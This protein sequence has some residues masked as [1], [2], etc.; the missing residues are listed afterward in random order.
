MSTVASKLDDIRTLKRRATGFRNLK[1]FKKALAIFEQAIAELKTLQASDQIT[2]TEASEV[3]VEL[4]DTYGMEGGTYSR[5]DELPNHLELALEQYRTGLEIERIDKKSTYNASNVIRL[6]ITLEK[7]P[8]D[9]AMMEDIDRVI[10]GLGTD[11][12]GER[13]DEFWAWA[14]LG[15][16]YLLRNDLNKARA[17]YR[18]AMERGPTTPELQRHI[19][20]LR[21]LAEATRASAKELSRNLEAAIAELEQWKLR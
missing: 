12:A 2:K 14:D 20:I 5:W 21:E 1:D 13:A 17:I 4:A 19:E 9:A 10:Q 15:Q 11:T 7:T 3:R 6:G 8:P 16:F 18:S